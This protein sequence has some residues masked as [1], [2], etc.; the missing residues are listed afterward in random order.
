MPAVQVR[1]ALLAST[2]PSASPG[3]AI[4]AAAPA[5][6][7]CASMAGGMVALEISIEAGSAAVAKTDVLGHD[8]DDVGACV[9]AIV[10]GLR[11]APPPTAETFLKEV[12]P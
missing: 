5:L 2:L 11:F 3:E 7:G 6:R 4:Q 10:A 12:H 8:A 9:Q 1:D